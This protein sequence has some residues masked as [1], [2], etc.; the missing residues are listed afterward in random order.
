V[1]SCTH[2]DI[3]VFSFHPV[4]IITT[5]EGGMAT[6]NDTD[7]AAR[8]RRLRSHGVA[9]DYELMK[10]RPE[11][12]I[13]NYQQI[14]LGFNY[15]LNEIQAALGMSQLGRLGQ[16]VKRRRE[17]ADEYNAAFREIPIITPYQMRGTSSSFHLYPIRVSRNRKKITQRK[18]YDTLWRN[19]IA[20]NLHY[21]PVH[22][23][24]YYE[25]LGFSSGDF[26]AAEC[27]HR[28]AISLPIFP[29]MTN[30]E[31]EWVIKVIKSIYE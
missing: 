11:D 2:S 6:T 5:G 25:N 14:E 1:G 28:E 27:F 22:R 13:W 19:N 30:G 23:Q 15:R 21:I 4:K 16:F 26:P 9:T 3:T 20:A 8:M 18:V 17:I 12:E 10:P 31:I 7:L 24:P 29:S